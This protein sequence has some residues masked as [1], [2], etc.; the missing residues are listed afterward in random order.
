M[1]KKKVFTAFICL[2]MAI[3]SYSQHYMTTSG[4]VSFLSK[5]PI[6]DISS[7]HETV[8]CV[9][10]PLKSE[11]AVKIPIKQFVF[12]NNLMR[13]HFNE[14]YMESDKFPYATFSG[15]INEMIDYSKSITYNVTVSGKLLIHGIEQART[16]TGTIK[17][18]D[19][20]M[21]L[22]T[23]F[24]VLL[25][26]HKIKRPSLMLVKI[27]DKIEVKAHFVLTPKQ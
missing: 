13:E 11:L 17:I 5:A 4:H 14:N 25:E 7:K 2:F 27:S 16:L 8:A 21:T 9:L 10:N 19:G 26:D 12:S 6:E 15:R 18:E 1:K 3:S 24:I 22:T 23:E 20:K